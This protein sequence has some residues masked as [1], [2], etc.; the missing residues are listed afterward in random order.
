[1]TESYKSLETKIRERQ[2]QTVRERMEAAALKRGKVETKDIEPAPIVED[3]ESVDEI[4]K[5]K[6]GAYVKGATQDIDNISSEL[7]KRHIRYNSFGDKEAAKGALGLAAKHL[8]RKAGVAKAVDKLVY[9]PMK[10]EEAEP[11]EELMQSPLQQKIAQEKQQMQKQRDQIKLQIAKEKAAK[12]EQAMK[13][14]GQQELAKI[15]EEEL[16]ERVRF[17]PT[18][19]NFG[20]AQRFS[21]LHAQ[22]YQ[23]LAAQGELGRAELH[24]KRMIEWKRRAYMAH[25]NP[26]H[27]QR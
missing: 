16:D 9:A 15:K 2:L 5:E 26:N 12:Q 17:S 7:T 22:A 25:D 18:P 19:A 8:K 10:N 13:Q 6:L 24:R 3:V 20:R 21:K 27:L 1:M 4:S 11:V 23:R 14:K